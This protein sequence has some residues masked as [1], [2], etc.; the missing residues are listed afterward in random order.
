MQISITSETNIGRSRQNDICI[1]QDEMVSR[2]HGKILFNAHSYW[3][4]DLGSINGTFVNAV[5]FFGILLHSCPRVRFFVCPRRLN[6]H[7]LRASCGVGQLT[8]G[9]ML[10]PFPQKQIAE[11]TTVLL[12]LGDEVEM[13]NSVF[14]VELVVPSPIEEEA[15]TSIDHDD[16]A[17]LQKDQDIGNGVLEGDAALDDEDE[18]DD[19]D[20]FDEDG[21][22]GDEDE[23]DVCVPLPCS[24]VLNVLAA[25]L[26]VSS[27][28]R[29][30]QWACVGLPMVLRLILT[31]S[32]VWGCL[33]LVTDSGVGMFDVSRWRSKEHVTKESSSLALALHFRLF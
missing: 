31:D 7:T 9:R 13:G 24:A 1:L 27:F 11:K 10:V 20:D 32:G 14:K 12:R 8:V 6:V 5:P 22:D 33:T 18:E 16:L 21:D 29:G 17:Q 19:V 2:K 3:L 4:Q 28:R 26:H 15:T 25:A 30:K 23:D